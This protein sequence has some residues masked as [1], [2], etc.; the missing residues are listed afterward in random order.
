MPTFFFLTPSGEYSI[1]GIHWHT[2]DAPLMDRNAT[3]VVF[4]PDNHYAPVPI[5]TATDIVNI[6]GTANAAGTFSPGALV[7]ALLPGNKTSVPIN[8]AFPF[9]FAFNLS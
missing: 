5:N 3:T 2:V 6:D 8:N 7:L 1:D 4:I 9:T